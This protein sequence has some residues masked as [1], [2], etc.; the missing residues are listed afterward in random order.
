[1]LRIEDISEENLEHVLNICSGNRAFAPI[2]DP[3]LLQGREKRRQW[4]LDMLKNHGPCAKL[5]YLDEKPV[6]QLVFYPEEVMPLLQCPR[7]DVVYIKCIFNS[8]KEDQ[9]KGVA[10][11]L[12][13]NLLQECRSGLKC[14]GSRSSQF[15]VTKPFPHEGNLPLS[16][17]YKKYGF[18]EGY[19]E[20]YLEICGRYSPMK[21]PE[22]RPLSEDGS[23]TIIAYNIDCEWGYYYAVTVKK[24]IQA[25]RPDYPVEIFSGWERPEEYKK[26]GGN[27]INIAAGILVNRRIPEAG[28]FWKDR[29]VYLR[30]I[31]KLITGT[32]SEV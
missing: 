29:E 20:M 1:M 13:K 16:D 26:R 11:A 23:K 30:T 21:L 14:L 22:F 3:I 9:K 17:F 5:G 19:K 32:Q 4:F 18:Q 6:A 15:V 25:K 28:A 8:T 2:D 24:L 10:D 7:R 12:M 27:W 31:E